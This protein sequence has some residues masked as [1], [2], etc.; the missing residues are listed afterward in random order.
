[1][2]DVAPPPSDAAAPVSAPAPGTRSADEI[3]R[4][5]ERQRNDLS[6]SVDALRGRVRELSDWRGHVR[7]HS[8][9]LI[10]GAAI[11]GFAVGGLIAL[12]RLGRR[13]Q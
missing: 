11:V 1:V 10:A 2:T 7:R 9:E 8:G 6:R 5:I 12:R 3:R 4:D 13:G